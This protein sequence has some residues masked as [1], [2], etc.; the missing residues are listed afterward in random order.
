[1]Y[2]CMYIYIYIYICM[3]YIDP[4]PKD[5]RNKSHCNGKDCGPHSHNISVTT[6]A[7]A[8]NAGEMR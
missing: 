6:A 2:V 5:K 1:M 8:H 7:N 3:L 4:I